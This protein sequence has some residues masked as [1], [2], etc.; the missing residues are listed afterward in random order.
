MDPEIKKELERQKERALREKELQASKAMESH[1]LAEL[2][3]LRGQEDRT[4]PE[5]LTPNR[6]GMCSCFPCSLYK[7]PSYCF[8]SLVPINALYQLQLKISISCRPNAKSVV[9]AFLS[10][11]IKPKS[12]P[13]QLQNQSHQ[14]YTLQWFNHIIP[15]LV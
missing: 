13:F 9:L 5:R 7:L 8:E 6:A 12:L 2:H 3:A 1:Y 14:D 4:K 11:Q 10:L 15:S